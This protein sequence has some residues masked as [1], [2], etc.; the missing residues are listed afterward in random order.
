MPAPL[1]SKDLLLAACAGN[2]L[3]PHPILQAA[4]R[5]SGLHKF[6]IRARGDQLREIDRERAESVRGIDCWVA[7]NKPEVRGGAYLHSESV[8]MV[9]DRIAAFAVEAWAALD[10]G[11]PEL[12]RHYMWQRLAQLALAYEDLVH[13]ISTGR[14]ILPDC[15]A[16]QWNWSE[17]EYPDELD[18]SPGRDRDSARW[19]R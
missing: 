2:M 4:H 11:I 3:V 10:R 1:P 19:V 15:P 5:L 9:I 17:K 7:A 16:L 18:R 12:E 8:G 6:R 13:E 14:R